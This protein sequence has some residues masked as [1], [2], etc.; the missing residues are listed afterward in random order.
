VQVNVLRIYPLHG[1][2]SETICC[3]GGST[4]LFCNAAQDVAERMAR[5]ARLLLFTPSVMPMDAYPLQHLPDEKFVVLVTAT[6][7]Q[8]SCCWSLLGSSVFAAAVAA[9]TEQTQQSGQLLNAQHQA[10]PACRD[11]QLQPA[12]QQSITPASPSCSTLLQVSIEST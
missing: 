1:F 2:E 5:E 3:I 6:T 11:Q 7:G 4:T 12:V 10:A 8:V 9:A